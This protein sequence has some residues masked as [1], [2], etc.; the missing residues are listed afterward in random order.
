MKIYSVEY[1]AK[2]EKS[3]EKLDEKTRAIIFRYIEKNLDGC[4]NP[5]LHGKALK[6][7]LRD[8]WS[9]RVGNYRIISEIHDEKI[10][11]LIVDV[12]HRKEV[13]KR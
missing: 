7:N 4:E 5:R 10:K 12:A 13:Y 9:Y 6:G 8:K 2:A 3:L 11:I 1:T